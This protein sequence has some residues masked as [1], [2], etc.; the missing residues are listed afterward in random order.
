METIPKTENEVRAWLLEKIHRKYEEKYPL[1]PSLDKETAEKLREIQSFLRYQGVPFPGEVKK[2]RQR[3]K[4]KE[5]KK[6]YRV[7]NHSS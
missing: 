3:T 1:D 4:K 5:A 2:R 7:Q 6:F